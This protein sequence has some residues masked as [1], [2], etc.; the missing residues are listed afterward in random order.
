MQAFLADESLGDSLDGVEAMI[1]KHEDFEKSF[2]AQEEK[3]KVSLCNTMYAT[4]GIEF[5]EVSVFYLIQYNIYNKIKEAITKQSTSV[6]GGGKG[7]FRG[8]SH[9]VAKNPPLFCW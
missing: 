7:R 9:T 1:K 6:Q 3:I 4:F 2:A 8:G 5:N